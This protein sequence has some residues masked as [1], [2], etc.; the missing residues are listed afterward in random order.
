MF[1]QT[2]KT[3]LKEQISSILRFIKKEEGSQ[4]LRNPTL[5]TV[6]VTCVCVLCGGDLIILF[7]FDK[8]FNTN[9][10]TPLGIRTRRTVHKHALFKTADIGESIRFPTGRCY[11]GTLP[12]LGSWLSISLVD[13][14]LCGFLLNLFFWDRVNFNTIKPFANWPLLC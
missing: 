12:T 13:Q 7:S 8:V 14:E 11:V 1:L 4:N 6:F 9:H 5:V 3:K 10:S 2:S